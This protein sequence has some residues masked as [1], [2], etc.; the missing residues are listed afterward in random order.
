MRGRSRSRILTFVGMVWLLLL[1][2]C[3]EWMVGW[4]VSWLGVVG[5]MPWHAK[6]YLDCMGWVVCIKVLFYFILYFWGVTWGK[7]VREGSR[8]IATIIVITM[9]SENNSCM[10]KLHRKIITFRS[11]SLSKL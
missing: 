8:L 3:D 4:L 5:M 6:L 11:T 1:L 7:V 9:M 10:P 2:L